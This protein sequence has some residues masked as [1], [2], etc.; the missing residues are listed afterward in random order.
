MLNFFIEKTETE[1]EIIY[2]DKFYW[3]PLLL[4]IL[5][6]LILV[7]EA[8]LTI[9]QSILDLLGAI[10]L[11]SFFILMI[12]RFVMQWKVFKVMKK[13]WV[14]VKGSVWSLKFP[15]TYKIKKK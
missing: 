15:L 2:K 6:F 11:G 3:L 12:P 5:F 7:L 8:Y 1:D 4:L 9:D 13:D 10:L 14:K